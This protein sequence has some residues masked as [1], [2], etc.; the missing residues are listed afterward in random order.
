MYEIYRYL[1]NS[2]DTVRAE[3]GLEDFAVAL[4]EDLKGNPE[5]YLRILELLTGKKESDIIKMTAQD[6]LLE[7]LEGLQQN[8]ILSF[9]GMFKELSKDYGPF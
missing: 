2:L 1:E 6:A 4:L 3:T 5:F 8:K 9:H 7:F